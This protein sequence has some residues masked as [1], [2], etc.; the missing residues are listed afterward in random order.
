M[1]R[2]RLID[3]GV[4]VIRSRSAQFVAELSEKLNA[5]LNVS[6][7]FKVASSKI[8]QFLQRGSN[9][10]HIS[11]KYYACP[12]H[13]LGPHGISQSCDIPQ[14]FFTPVSVAGDAREVSIA[15]RNRARA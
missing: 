6:P 9:A 11:K 1:L 8:T 13:S 4:E 7:S 2:A 14:Y 5:R 12:R 15:R 3:P 10:V